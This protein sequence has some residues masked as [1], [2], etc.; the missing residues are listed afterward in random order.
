MNN[1]SRGKCLYKC[2]LKKGALREYIENAIE[3]QEK[4]RPS[5]ESNY[6]YYGKAIDKYKASFNTIEFLESFSYPTSAFIWRETKEG[7][8]F[9]RQLDVE[10][11][12]EYKKFNSDIG[13]IKRIHI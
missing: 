8:T 12:N 9:W 5:D 7:D 4:F 6:I 11:D 2:L 10:L 1:F 3:Y 13:V